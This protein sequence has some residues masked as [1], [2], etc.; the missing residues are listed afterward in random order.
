MIV[1]GL[2]AGGGVEKCEK[3]TTMGDVVNYTTI[4]GAMI[5]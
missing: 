1:D 4:R 2:K 3:T 5:K